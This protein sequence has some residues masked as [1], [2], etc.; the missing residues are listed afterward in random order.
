MKKFFTQSNC[1]ICKAFFNKAIY[2]SQSSSENDDATGAVWM[3]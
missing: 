2:I 1:C 3:T